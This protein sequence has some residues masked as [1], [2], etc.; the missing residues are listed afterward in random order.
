LA[1]AIKNGSTNNPTA[2]RKKQNKKK[3]TKHACCHGEN[4]PK[5]ERI[6]V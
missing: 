2:G 5:V 3:E 4:I 1:F 6:T